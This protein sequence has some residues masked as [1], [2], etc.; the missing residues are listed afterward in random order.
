EGALVSQVEANSPGAKA[1]LKTGDIITG[2]DGQ[3]VTDSGELQV[4][5]GQKRPGT[6]INLDV[7]RDGNTMKV[8]VTLEAMGKRDR[9]TESGNAEQ[10]RPGWGLG[11]QEL[12]PDLR[13]QLQVPSDI[14]GAVIGNVQPGSAADNAGLQRGD[15][16]VEINRR[17]V[18]SDADAVDQL[19]GIPNGQDALVLVWSNG[20]RTYRVLDPNQG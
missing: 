10:G 7:L 9:E 6:T 2:I 17:P 18:K 14:Q 15:V 3:P 13:E 19:K 20:G 12:T 4:L 5:V 1:G 8:P 11:L 16:I